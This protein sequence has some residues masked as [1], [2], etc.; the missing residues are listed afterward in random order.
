MFLRRS[1]FIKDEMNVFK[2]QSYIYSGTPFITKIP[3]DKLCARVFEKPDL[4]AGKK[5]F[6]CWYVR[7]PHPI[8][9]GY[10][11][12][13][14]LSFCVNFILYCDIPSEW[15]YCGLEREVFWPLVYEAAG[16]VSSHLKLYYN[17]ELLYLNT[18]N[19]PTAQKYLF[20]AD[21]YR[22][23]IKDFKPQ[24]LNEFL[25]EGPSEKSL[26]FQY[27]WGPAE[28]MEKPA[29]E[30]SNEYSGDT[31]MNDDEWLEGLLRTCLLISNQLNMQMLCPRQSRGQ[32]ELELAD[33]GSEF[34]Q[35]VI[36]HRNFRFSI[37]DNYLDSKDQEE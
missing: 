17:G 11:W 25:S 26:G 29:Y 22:Y 15:A 13:M 8:E 2:N 31:G 35:S 30:Y 1:E 5:S 33:Y 34:E 27:A 37:F 4:E 3:R 7:K 18:R 12:E 36:F 19:V 6:N 16:E 20:L 28:G 21:P 10:A 14:V 23:L 32:G 9:V 24:N